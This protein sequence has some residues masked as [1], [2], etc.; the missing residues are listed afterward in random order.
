MLKQAL[1]GEINKKLKG[2]GIECVNNQR[3]DITIDREFVDASWSSGKKTISYH[4]MAYFDESEKIIFL[5]EL[6]KEQGSGI[7][8]GVESES[9]FQTGMTLHRKV[10]YM[11]YGVEGKAYECTLDLGEIPKTFKDTAI[12]YGWKLKTVIKKEKAMYPKGYI[13]YNIPQNTPQPNPQ[14]V[15][16]PNPQY[17]PQPNPQYVSQPNPQYAPQ[18]NPQYVQQPNPQYASQPNPQYTGQPYAPQP[19]APK[20]KQKGIPFWISLLPLIF[21]SGVLYLL[22]GAAVTGG[23][24][25][26]VILITLIV[27][28]KKI[29][30]LGC[31]AELLIWVAVLIVLFLVFALTLA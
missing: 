6:T 20:Q 3:T 26:A 22:G 21:V 23:I 11:Q 24:I 19:L 1:I 5:W 16:Q 29:R 30:S 7:S 2:L 14:Y 31:L 13:P 8:F 15:P 28:G 9:S 4:A 18:P 10:K 25:T 17:M 12:A 27:L